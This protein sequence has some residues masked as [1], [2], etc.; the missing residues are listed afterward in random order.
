MELKVFARNGAESG[1][2]VVLDDAVFGIEPNDHV[3]WLDVKA[4]QAHAR[5]GTHKTKERGEVAY[6]TRKLYRQ[7]G[8]GG[9]RA[10][11]RKSP[12]RV[13]GGTIFGPKPHAYTVGVNKKTKQLARRSA[14]AHKLNAEAVRIVEDLRLDAPKTRDVVDLLKGLEL[15]ERKVLLLTA[16]HDDTLYRSGRNLPKLT[17]RR[18]AEAS[19]LDLMNAQV[20]LLQEGAVEPLTE[21]LRP[22]VRANGENGTDAPAG[23]EAPETDASETAAP[24]GAD[25]QATDTND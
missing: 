2:T 17:I 1:R 15:G 10:G 22:K 24:A 18:A 9:A 16:E 3:I 7:K 13:G 14:I 8:T 11:D 20:L 12:V 25:A 19:T 6:S 4:A 23:A 21:A 5:Q